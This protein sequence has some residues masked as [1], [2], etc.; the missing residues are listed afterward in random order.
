MARVNYGGIAKAI[1]AVIEA[2][3]N[4]RDYQATVELNPG[5]IALDKF[6]HVGVYERT[7]RA[8][9]S[10]PIAAGRQARFGLRWDVIVSAFGRDF[11]TASQTRDEILGHIEIALMANR[12][13]GGALASGSLELGGGELTGGPTDTGFVSQGSIS[14]SA[15]VTATV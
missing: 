12:T 14:L 6:A 1:K 8:P 9:G 10:Q 4:V 3:P 7:R 11:E 15:E 13:L 5:T 2:D